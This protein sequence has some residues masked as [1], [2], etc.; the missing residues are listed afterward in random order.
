MKWCPT[1]EGVDTETTI[2]IQ[3]VRSLPT[4]TKNLLSVA[5]WWRKVSQWCF[6]NSA[7]KFVGVRSAPEG[8]EDAEY[9]R[10]HKPNHHCEVTAAARIG[11]SRRR[12]TRRALSG[13]VAITV[14]DTAFVQHR[15]HEENECSHGSEHSRE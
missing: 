13:E 2:A 15:V 1:H 3:N 4:F 8:K 6:T 5:Q 9:V 7:Q 14:W 10:D 12:N 11:V